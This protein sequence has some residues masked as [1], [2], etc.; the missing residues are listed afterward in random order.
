MNNKK[1]DF[2]TAFCLIFASFCLSAICNYSLNMVPNPHCVSE[3]LAANLRACVKNSGKQNRVL[4]EISTTYSH[5]R[6]FLDNPNAASAV[7]KANENNSVYFQYDQGSFSMDPLTSVNGEVF[8]FGYFPESLPLNINLESGKYESDHFD[9]GSSQRHII[10]SKSFAQSICS[11]GNCSVLIGE[12]IV[13]KLSNFDFTIDAICNDSCL[14]TDFSK[15]RPFVIGSFYNFSSKYSSEKMI[16]KLAVNYQNNLTIFNKIFYN[17]AFASPISLN[18]NV[19]FD[20]KENNWLYLEAKK[21]VGYQSNL[22]YLLTLFS[23][24][25]FLP[26]VFVFK[27]SLSFRRIKQKIGNTGCVLITLFC[28]LSIFYCGGLFSSLFKFNGFFIY[29]FSPKTV[30]IQ[31]VVFPLLVSLYAYLYKKDRGNYSQ[32]ETSGGQFARIEI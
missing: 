30:I 24:I 21:L 14:M 27:K 20:M 12:K 18:S 8:A 15:D 1:K 17:P 11:S 26:L 13:D 2:L 16:G 32:F 29:E 31:I 5:S 23:S 9:V 6:Y 3:Y 4:F 10:L 22:F 25:C 28:F 7:A 19:S